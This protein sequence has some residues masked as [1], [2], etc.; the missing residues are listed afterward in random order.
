MLCSHCRLLSAV[1]LSSLSFSLFLCITNRQRVDWRL[2]V[3]GELWD[4]SPV[5][6]FWLIVNCG[7]QESRGQRLSPIKAQTSLSFCCF[8]QTFDV[9]FCFVCRS[10]NL[11]LNFLDLIRK[12]ISQPLM[13]Q[14]KTTNGGSDYVPKSK[15]FRYVQAF[16]LLLLVLTF[17]VRSPY[18]HSKTRSSG[19]CTTLEL[20][21]P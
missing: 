3:R 1:W 19:M 6:V 13:D 9:L 10:S 11:S 21:I 15:Q 16:L 5:P 18:F 20:N 4:Q 17:M 8:G 12:L 14:T 7:T 2:H